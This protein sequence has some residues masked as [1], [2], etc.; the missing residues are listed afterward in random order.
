[1]KG[2]VIG[3]PTKQDEQYWF[4]NSDQFCYRPLANV[5]TEIMVPLASSLCDKINLAGCTGRN[6]EENYFWKYN[7]R[8]QYLDL[9]KYVMETWP[10]FFKYRRYE[11]Y[12]D[13]YC[14]IVEEQL[15]YGESIGKEYRNIITSYIPA[16][17]KR[18]EI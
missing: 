17:V 11:A 2:K 1:M 6:E 5:M 14:Q 18:N 8:T 13:K 16:L 7:D 3:I 4:L 9:K 12:Y 15:S 10:A